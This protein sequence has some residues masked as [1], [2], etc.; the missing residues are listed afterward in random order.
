[1]YAT[2]DDVD[3][4]N[5]VNGVKALSKTKAFIKL[6]NTLSWFFIN[7][8]RGIKTCEIFSILGQK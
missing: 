4:A 8:I 7:V 3:F 2:L 5:M 6:R 1:M